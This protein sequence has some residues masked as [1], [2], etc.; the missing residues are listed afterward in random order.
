MTLDTIITIDLTKLGDLDYHWFTNADELKNHTIENNK[1]KFTV[2][3]ARAWLHFLNNNNVDRI[4]I[5]RSGTIKQGPTIGGL[6]FHYEDPQCEIKENDLIKIRNL[7]TNSE[8]T[9]TFSKDWCKVALAILRKHSTRDEAMAKR[10]LQEEVLPPYFKKVLLQDE[11]PA[12]SRS[13]TATSVGKEQNE[14]ER[15]SAYGV[16]LAA[17]AAEKARSDAEAAALA[18]ASQKPA[19]TAASTTSAASPAAASAPAAPILPSK[20]SGQDDKKKGDKA[21]STQPN[22]PNQ[23]NQPAKK[24]P[25]RDKF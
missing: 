23:P 15:Y 10:Y 25:L 20:S 21:N 8:F 4:F 18:A 6:P 2:G 11:K 7:E 1:V 3:E 22:Q 5:N 13:G 14:G 19:S 24:P 16:W 12:P 9:F 17:Q